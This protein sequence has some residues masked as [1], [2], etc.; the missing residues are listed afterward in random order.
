MTAALRLVRRFRQDPGAVAMIDAR[1]RTTTYGELLAAIAQTRSA[2]TETGLAPGSRVILQTPPGAPFTQA[3]VALLLEG[4]VPVGIEAAQ[5]DH[6]YRDRAAAVNAAAVITSPVVARLQKVPAV[7][8][9]MAASGIMV[10]PPLALPQLGATTRPRHTPASPIAPDV[11]SESDALIVFTGGTTGS[12]RGVRLSHRAVEAYLDGLSRLPEW[13]DLTTIAA[14][15]PQQVVYGLAHG[16]TV[17]LTRPGNRRRPRHLAQLLFRDGVEGYFGSPT[18]WSAVL[19]QN[20]HRD[21]TT[22]PRAV[23]VGGAPVTRP[24]LER[25]ERELP[26]STAVRCLYGMTEVGLIAHIDGADKL[27]RLRA[28]ADGDPVGALVAGCRASV[29]DGELEVSTPA[30]FSGYLD[31]ADTPADTTFATGDLATMAGD[32]LVL[33]GRKKDMIV[34]QGVNLY[35]GQFEPRLL[36]LDHNGQ[37]AFDDVALVRG[38][39]DE[40]GDRRVTSAPAIRRARRR[41]LRAVFHVAHRHRRGNRLG[42]RLDA[43]PDRSRSFGRHA[44]QRAALLRSAG[45]DRS[46]G[47][48]GCGRIEGRGLDSVTTSG[49]LPASEPRS[50]EDHR[51]VRRQAAGDH[52]A[53]DQKPPSCASPVRPW[54]PL[55][56]PPDDGPRVHPRTPAQRHHGSA[57]SAVPAP[58]HRGVHS[59]RHGGAP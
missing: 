35:A 34:S 7:R 1:N 54:A 26:V 15:H 21:A 25:F 55:V 45:Q 4:L 28:G 3:A 14:D 10:P 23:L 36:T 48:R 58:R 17:Y 40:L 41:T 43:V 22:T 30:R 11:D 2:I 56:T 42:A 32:E 46:L 31:D 12:P 8:R 53:L 19:D 52:T 6:V 38:P 49:R 27:A 39:A 18:T 44:L 33:L 5:G 51:S 13:N 47:P 16:K 29:V 57:S 24:M 37:R 9:R 59:P 20:L 50:A